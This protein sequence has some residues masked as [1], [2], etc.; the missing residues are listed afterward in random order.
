MGR[1]RPIGAALNLV[2]SLV[3]A[4]V[5]LVVCTRGAGP[6]PPLGPVLN[7]GSGVWT[8]ASDGALP[9]STTFHLAGLD[10]PVSIVF[11][12]NGT[13]HIA[14]AT[15]HD[16]FLALGYVHA[17]YRLSQMDYTRRRGEGLLSEVF[18]PSQLGGD[19][20]EVQL[21]IAR[22]AKATW[23][24]TPPGS[25]AYGALMAY[26][27][28]VNDR[29]AVAAADNSLP[30]M[31][32]L[33]GY[34]PSAWT[35]VDSL[36]VQGY[37][38][39]QLS[40]TSK[41]LDTAVLSATIGFTRTKEWFPTVP[42]DEQ[43][44]WD[45]GPYAA[46]TPT[47]PLPPTTA[48]NTLSP[49][50]VGSLMT[51]GRP[52]AA[53]LDPRLLHQDSNSNAV[54]IDGTKTASG[55][56]MLLGDPHLGLTLPSF[57]YQIEATSPSYRVA[58]ATTPGLPVVFS[59]RNAH[60]AWSFSNVQSRSALYYVEE[61]SRAHV[62]QYYWRGAWRAFTGL[63]TI[64]PVKNNP[65][66]G[67][68]VLYS[69]HG[70]A[71]RDAAAPASTVTLAWMG[72]LPSFNVA[73][74]L[75]V[76]RASTFA[77]FRAALA[78]WHAPAQTFVY[79][80]DKGNIGAVAPG[81]YPVVTHGDPTLPLP[82][83]GA[84]DVAGVAPYDRVPSAYN[85]SS[86]FIDASDQRPVSGAY[87]YDIGSSDNFFDNGY[88]ASRLYDLLAPAKKLTLSDAEK[89][90]TDTYDALASRI[91]PSLLAALP[92]SGL[93]G[94]ETQAR[95][96]LASW[97]KNVTTSSAAATIWWTF[98]NQYL[99][100]TFAP[101]WQKYKVP[102]QKFFGVFLSY[103]Q[104]AL[105]ED[106]E[107]WTLHDP[108]NATFTPPGG[109]ARNAAAV[110]RAAFSE[111]VAALSSSN[112]IGPNPA[113]WTW[114]KVS[115]RE[116]DSLLPL[117]PIPGNSAAPLPELTYGPH[118]SDGD[119][120]TVSPAGSLGAS[121]RLIVD[122]GSGQAEAAYP[123]GQS[124]N[125][126]SPWYTDRMDLWWSGGYAPLND[127]TMARAQAGAAVWTATP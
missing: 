23:A 74:L 88:R 115:Q 121:W 71:I 122:W 14:A 51:S 9:Q 83:D 72:S 16:L 75:N 31:F 47:T 127:A 30:A 114:D 94:N 56:A 15:D 126:L 13:A 8:V 41:P 66:V 109:S 49:R 92:P 87:P 77:A 97:N 111:V 17:R 96:L 123:G 118:P 119:P 28:G 38:T 58:G 93:D 35:P 120:W 5:V 95:A 27:Q 36:A 26:A 4:A 78:D 81:Y 67:V 79:A 98:W 3:A 24:A 60:I 84:S 48:L 45:A 110:M 7:P 61:T 39:Q 46:G 40:L 117:K 63:D 89:I 108:T 70:P 6:L 2:V 18:G 19:T 29:I 113:S 54:A 42:V 82:G 50:T 37:L 106:L 124:E 44:P 68:P 62:G 90:Q 34:V 69:V 100:D 104:A 53:V 73:A 91:M 20:L 43:H 22:T 125:P 59:G 101:W 10:R 57:W 80:D 64:I 33:R 85:P 112:G 25:H 32:K 1:R 116:I 99:L 76:E 103:S 102:Q 86:H 107:Q 105:D 52:V 12:K 55:K 11:E 65:S 21:G